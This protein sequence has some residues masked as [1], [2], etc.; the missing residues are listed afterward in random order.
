MSLKRR[1][2]KTLLTVYN[3]G[4]PIPNDELHKIFE[5][6]YRVDKAR[7]VKNGS[8]L[9]LSIAKRIAEDHG[10]RIGVSSND[11]GT[12]FFIEFKNVKPKNI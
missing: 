2:D 12:C 8:G 10:T 5:R 9:G 6:F 7:T 4:D 1:Y 3:S 11:S